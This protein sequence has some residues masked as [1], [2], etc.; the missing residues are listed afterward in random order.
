MVRTSAGSIFHSRNHQSKD[1]V[2][3]RYRF[4]FTRSSSRNLRSDPFTPS[5]KNPYDVLKE[6]LVKRTVASEQKR[7]QQLFSSEELGDRKPTQLLR[8]LQQ[9]AGDTTGAD[10]AFLCELFLQQLPANV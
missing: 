2:Q 7:L 3:L 9:L 6:Q 10:G 1:H 8:R 5:R 4:T